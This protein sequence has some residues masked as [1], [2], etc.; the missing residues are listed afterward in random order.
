MPQENDV[1]GY[2]LHDQV[3]YVKEVQ[4][5]YNFPAYPCRKINSW[6]ENDN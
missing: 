4:Y 1:Y 3:I 5:I 2:L 6:S